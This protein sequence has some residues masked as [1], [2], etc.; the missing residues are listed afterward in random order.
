MI[1]RLTVRGTYEPPLG[2]LGRQLN[3]T[4]MQGVA[5]GTVKDLAESIAKQIDAAVSAH[6][7]EDGAEPEPR[8]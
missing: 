4:V 2:K 3:E 7:R 5:D 8:G 1:S 6:T